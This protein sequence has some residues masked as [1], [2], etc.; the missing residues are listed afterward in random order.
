MGWAGPLATRMLADLGA[1]VIKVESEGHPDWWRG[2]EAS[3]G[4]ESS[5]RELRPNFNT[6]NRG[7][8]GVSLDLTAEPGRAAAR[9]LVA[10]SD[11]VIE[12]FAAGVLAKLGLGLDVQRA[13][14]P[15]IVSVAMPA[16]GGSGPLAAT[17]ALRL[18]RR[19]GLRPAVRQRRGNLA[20][21]PAARGVR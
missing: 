15:G 20:A 5:R 16:F 19:A 14:S 17:R 2:W 18:D 6:V 4:D 1:D 13:L 10:G 11:V 7:K 9:A 8:R 3:D 12:N 21:L